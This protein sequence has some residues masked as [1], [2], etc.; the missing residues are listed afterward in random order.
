MVVLR[1]YLKAVVALLG[2]I[3]VVN[4]AKARNHWG[5]RRKPGV[6]RCVHNANLTLAE[7]VAPQGFVIHNIIGPSL[8]IVGGPHHRA[9]TASRVIIKRVR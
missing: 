2:L 3:H 6:Q 1:T 8:A 9:G 4:P 5:R 7:P